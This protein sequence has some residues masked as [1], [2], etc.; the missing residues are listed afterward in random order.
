MP[1]TPPSLGPRFQHAV[2][3]LP[4]PLSFLPKGMDTGNCAALDRERIFNMQSR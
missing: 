2:A 1:G 4:Y 3:L